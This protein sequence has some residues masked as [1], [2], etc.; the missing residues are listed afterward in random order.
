MANFGQ[1][2]GMVFHMWLGH[3]LDKKTKCRASVRK[4]RNPKAPYRNFA[5]EESTQNIKMMLIEIT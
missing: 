3:P 5:Y 1:F 4:K 2:R